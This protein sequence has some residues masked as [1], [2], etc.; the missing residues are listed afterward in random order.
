MYKRIHTNTDKKYV[1]FTIS[2]QNELQTRNLLCVLKFIVL[3]TGRMHKRLEILQANSDGA[4]HGHSTCNNAC[5]MCRKEHERLS[6]PVIRD[7]LKV[8]LEKLFNR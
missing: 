5:P 4:V 3:K 1:C 8:I 7:N 6:M 2:A